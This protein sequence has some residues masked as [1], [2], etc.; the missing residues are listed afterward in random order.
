M[1]CSD[2]GG[3]TRA[4]LFKAAEGRTQSKTLRAQGVAIVSGGLWNAS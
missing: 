1:V 3:V 2:C 4:L